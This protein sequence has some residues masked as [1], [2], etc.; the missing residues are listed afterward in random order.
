MEKKGG[1]SQGK[2]R[3]GEEEC[4][5]KTVRMQGKKGEEKNRCR[6]KRSKRTQKKEQKRAEA[7]ERRM[8]I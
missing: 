5:C 4:R 6:R 1:R 3:I 2:T 8:K 7:E